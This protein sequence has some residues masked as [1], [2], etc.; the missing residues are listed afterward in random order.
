MGAALGKASCTCGQKSSHAEASGGD[1]DCPPIGICSDSLGL[2]PASVEYLELLARNRIGD[3][4]KE[5]LGN[6]PDCIDQVKPD[7][8]QSEIGKELPPRNSLGLS[9]SQPEP[10]PPTGEGPLKPVMEARVVLPAATPAAAPERRIPASAPQGVV[11][12]ARSSVSK[13]PDSPKDKRKSLLAKGK[14]P[15]ELPEA[16]AEMPEPKAQVVGEKRKD[17]K[18]K[19]E[20][21]GAG[22]RKKPGR[23]SYLQEIRDRNEQ[24]AKDKDKNM[25][26]VDDIMAGKYRKEGAGQPGGNMRIKMPTPADRRNTRDMILGQYRGQYAKIGRSQDCPSSSASSAATGQ[27]S[28]SETDAL[29]IIGGHQPI[30]RPSHVDLPKDFRKHIG[31]MSLQELGA[32]NSE[33]KRMLCSVYGDIFDV[34]DRPD[35]YATDAPYSWMSGKDITWGFVSGRDVPET[36]NKCFDL[37]KVAPEPFKDS[38]LKLIYAWVAFYEWEYG[39]AVGQLDLYA[40]EAALKGPP[41]EE[42]EDCCIM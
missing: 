21:E 20:K 36:T 24:L 41:M 26:L 13:E 38:K 30:P 35:K 42:S 31:K 29:K 8:L 17:K 32:Y 9:A 28:A 23:K 7:I 18:E 5:A 33:N 16:K 3:S 1:A 25:K 2:R 40:N 11:A 27:Y 12:P 19:K 10:E 14:V 34:S 6:S 4:I 15:V 39:N 22:Q 37:W